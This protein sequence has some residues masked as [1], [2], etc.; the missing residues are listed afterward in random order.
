MPALAWPGR[1]LNERDKTHVSRDKPRR[2]SNVYV[3]ER[4]DCNHNR[5]R[6][7]MKTLPA[8]L[9]NYPVAS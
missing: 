2:R 8:T 1:R 4:N 9:V 7:T 6:N 5:Q 3:V